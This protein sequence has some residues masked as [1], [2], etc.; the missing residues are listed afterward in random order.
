MKQSITKMTACMMLAVGLALVPTTN[1]HAERGGLLEWAI[2]SIAKAFPGKAA[3]RSA[4]TGGYGHG[5]AHATARGVATVEAGTKVV[6]AKVRAPREGAQTMD[7]NELAWCMGQEKTMK[8]EADT[9]DID[10][11]RVDTTSQSA[12]D[13]YNARVRRHRDL[14]D[15]YNQIC[16]GPKFYEGHKAAASRWLAQSRQNG[17]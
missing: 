14:V 16:V 3:K 4:D 1:A 13:G 6:A 10:F 7:Q 8:Q 2:T 9:L 5:V 15:R 11:H 12:V 17:H